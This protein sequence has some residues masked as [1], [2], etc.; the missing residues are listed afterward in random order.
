[1]FALT[2]HFLAAKALRK[3]AKFGVAMNGELL[4]KW[5]GDV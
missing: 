1:L 2:L 3:S 4:R 5:E